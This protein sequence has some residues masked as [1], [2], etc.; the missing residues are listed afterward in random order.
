MHIGLSME[1]VM[2]TLDLDMGAVR[3]IG[4]GQGRYKSIDQLTLRVER[5]RGV[6]IGTREGER[7]DPATMVE[8]KQRAT[9]AWNEAI[10]LYTGIIHMGEPWDWD[11]HGQVC[12]KQ[13]D[14]LPMTILAIM[15]DTSIGG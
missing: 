2:T 14:P 9:E 1:A 5:T 13:F 7:N 6:F 15:P 11:E 10:G 4:S 3:G 8:Y 12:V